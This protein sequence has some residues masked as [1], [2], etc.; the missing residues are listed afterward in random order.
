MDQDYVEKFKL[1][2]K[3]I[4]PCMQRLKWF[5]LN[6][7]N[8]FEWEYGIHA[9]QVC[10][11]NFN[12]KKLC[13]QGIL[14]KKNMIMVELKRKGDEIGIRVAKWE[15]PTSMMRIEASHKYSND[16]R[17]NLELNILGFMY[18]WCLKHDWTEP[19]PLRP[20]RTLWVFEINSRQ[21]VCGCIYHVCYPFLYVS[22]YWD[23]HSIESWGWLA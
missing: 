15:W 18:R 20:C 10:L 12:K 2:L 17:L 1:K 5:C 21:R 7:D 6:F 3:G 9:I 4:M 19:H 16:E 11:V 23:C 14:V 22:D 8:L 13:K